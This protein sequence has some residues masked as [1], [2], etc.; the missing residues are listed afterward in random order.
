MKSTEIIVEQDE[1]VRAIYD[2][3]IRFGSLG[4]ASIRRASHVEPNQVGQW[5][6]DL[7]PVAGPTL[8]PFNVR[9]E[10]L[11]TA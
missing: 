1:A 11:R 8:G 10:A 4:Q 2:E 6:A 9:S 7:S 5:T 3:A